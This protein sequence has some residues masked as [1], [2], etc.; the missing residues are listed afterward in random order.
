MLQSMRDQQAKSDAAAKIAAEQSAQSAREQT[1]AFHLMRSELKTLQQSTADMREGNA[2]TAKFAA[3][4]HK[5][6]ANNAEYPLSQVLAL[7]HANSCLEFTAAEDDPVSQELAAGSASLRTALDL[8]ERRLFM[9]LVIGYGYTWAI[10]KSYANSLPG[11]VEFTADYE[12]DVLRLNSLVAGGNATAPTG[13]V[14]ASPSS[15]APAIAVVNS[16]SDHLNKDSHKVAKHSYE[17]RM[18]TAA[19]LSKK[20]KQ[21]GKGKQK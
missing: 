18:A 9:C 11:P 19:Q 20:A 17:Q 4:P 7:R 15:A 6:G 12:L 8:C 21:G 5:S 3:L 2:L 13:V 10:A 14:V 16:K 1:Q